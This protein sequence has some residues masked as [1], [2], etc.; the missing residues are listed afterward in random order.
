MAILLSD[1]IDY[2]AP[3]LAD[4][5]VQFNGERP[6][7]SLEEAW[8]TVPMGSRALGLRQLIK[9]IEGGTDEWVYKEGVEDSDLI[10]VS[11]DID[12]SNYATKSE[13]NNKVDKVEGKDLIEI[14]E[15]NRL[16]NLKLVDYDNSMYYNM[17]TSGAMLATLDSWDGVFTDSIV[18][19]IILDG[20]GIIGR[21]YV[22]NEEVGS[23]TSI[24]GWFTNNKK[25]TLFNEFKYFTGIM[26]LDN[27]AFAGCSSLTSIILPN[28]IVKLGDNCFDGCESLTSI[29]I[30]EN[31][32]T[33]GS[34]CFNNTTMTV[35][36]LSHH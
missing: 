6:Y 4:N 29:T 18:G 10:L 32:T 3:K 1:N 33:M 15:I 26:T 27:Y 2:K 13:V 31:V 11:Y 23:I 12:L 35:T 17:T 20:L 16:K 22:T 25:I 8:E 7:T 30:P 24:D 19:Q 5:R 34:S 9:N 36:F 14:F 28:S 21:S